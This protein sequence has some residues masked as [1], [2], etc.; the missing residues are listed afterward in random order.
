MRYGAHLWQRVV[1]GHFEALAWSSDHPDQPGRDPFT[2][3]FDAARQQAREPFEAMVTWL[4][5]DH[6]GVPP[7]AA[8]DPVVAAEREEPRRAE[9]EVGVWRRCFTP[10]ASKLWKMDGQQGLDSLAG[11]T[12]DDEWVGDCAPEPK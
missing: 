11:H 5:L 3:R 6:E 8:P 12:V 10:R 7:F 4:G 1:T 9:W 2:L